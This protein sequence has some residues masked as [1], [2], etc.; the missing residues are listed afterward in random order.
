MAEKNEILEEIF[1]KNDRI[2]KLDVGGTHKF[3][4]KKS[5]LCSVKDS[6]LAIVFSDD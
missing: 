3:K 2:F 5:L 4:V 6:K 1:G